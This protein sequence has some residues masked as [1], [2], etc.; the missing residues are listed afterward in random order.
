M[1]EASRALVL[2]WKDTLEFLRDRRSIALMLVSAFLFP[3]LGL[4]VTGLRAHQRAAVVVLLCDHGGA[5]R[6]AGEAIV[7]ALR[8]YGSFN[9]TLVSSPARC[10]PV[11]G[12]VATV[13]VPPGFTANASRLSSVAVIRLYQAVGNPAASDVANIVQA[14]AQTLSERIAAARVSR[15]ADMAGVK[16]S[17]E[18]V[19]HPL[20]VVA[21]GVTPSGAPATPEEEER[22]SAA[23]FLAFSVFF[24]LNPAALA[25]AD[26]V[27]R[28]RESGTGEML[29]ITPLTG[30]DFVAG[31]ALGSLSAAMLAGGIDFAAA[32]SYAA[33]TGFRT[34]DMGL[35]A[36][37]ALE[38]I[39]AIIVTM[40]ITVLATLLVPGQRA[41]TLMTSTI[42]GAAIMVFF[43]VLFVDIASLPPGIRLLLYL[44][45]YTHT[46]LAIESYALGDAAGAAIHTLILAAAAAAALLAAARAYRPERLVRQRQ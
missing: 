41:A 14:V 40:A 21:T 1:R 9:V 7:E 24:V 4:M 45:P 23:R 25:V 16:A 15:L 28:E 32:L 34:A 27:S 19:L 20:R 43:S 10:G 18:A 29:A 30:L 12:A 22:A 36:L 17:P 31:K 42:T 8:S 13:E 11:P 33:L 5:A 3:L 37:H 6:E 46:A 2:A 35:V 44:I 26:A 39:V 38:T